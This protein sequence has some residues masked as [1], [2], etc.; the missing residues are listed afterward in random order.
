VQFGPRL[1]TFDK[2][3]KNGSYVSEL[4]GFVAIF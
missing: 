2:E 4:Y 1:A 3:S